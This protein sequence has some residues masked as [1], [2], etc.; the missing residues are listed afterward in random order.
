MASENVEVVRRMAEAFESGGLNAAREYY[1]PGI[2]WHEDPSFPEA[3][4]YRGVEAVEAYH[5]QFLREF[6]E[7]HYQPREL[8][9]VEDHVITNM[10]IHGRGK[11]SGA[12]FDIS[13]WWV[14]TV[15]E[16]RVI[17]VKAYLDRAEA[18]EAVGL[19]E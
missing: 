18:L 13:G 11:A 17:R 2:E 7:I 12:E 8:I 15:R 1:H 9:E 4:V 3:D 10:W 19:R 5:R 14:Y 16:G 6:A